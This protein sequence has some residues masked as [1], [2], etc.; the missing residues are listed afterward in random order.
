MLR[1]S[2]WSGPGARGQGQTLLAGRER[3]AADPDLPVHT[4]VGPLSRAHLGAREC[5]SLGFWFKDVLA[6]YA[7]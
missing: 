4:L 1:S 5:R 3:L 2:R 6:T 7:T